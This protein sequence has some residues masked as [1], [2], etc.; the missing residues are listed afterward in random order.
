MRQVFVALVNYLKNT[1]KSRKSSCL[2]LFKTHGMRGKVRA[3]NL[4]RDIA[5]A[6]NFDEARS[7]LIDFFNSSPAMR[8][9]SFATEL[10]NELWAKSGFLEMMSDQSIGCGQD[11]N[12][13]VSA[14]DEK[15]SPRYLGCQVFYD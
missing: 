9:K 2:R 8:N 1:N 5:A 11:F 12:G 7:I 13:V 15:T 3:E 6:E 14:L 10:L 4:V